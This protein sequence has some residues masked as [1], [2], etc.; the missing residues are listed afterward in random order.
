[1]GHRIRAPA[2]GPAT[3][4]ITQPPVF[5]TALRFVWDALPDGVRRERKE[6][7]AGLYRAALASHRWWIA[8]P[9]P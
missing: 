7:M 6:R 1:M 9:R 2:G 3:S 5:A 8:R 4:G